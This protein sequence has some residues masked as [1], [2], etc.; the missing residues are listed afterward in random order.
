[1]HKDQVQRN[2]QRQQVHEQLKLF[3]TTSD[4]IHISSTDSKGRWHSG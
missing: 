1:M 2:T 4:K 3:Y